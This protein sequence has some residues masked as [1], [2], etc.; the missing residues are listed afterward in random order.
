MAA[1]GID[2]PIAIHQCQ[3]LILT[4]GKTSSKKNVERDKKKIDQLKNIG[5]ET[6]I[7]WECRIKNELDTQ[8]DEIQRKLL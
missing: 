3:N 5:W 6:L 8:I 4:F 2:A 7:I 1:F